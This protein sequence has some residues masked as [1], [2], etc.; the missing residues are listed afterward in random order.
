MYVA[1]CL[2]GVPRNTY[3]PTWIGK[4]CEKYNTKVF[5]N[6]WLP[7][8]DFLQ[9]SNTPGPRDAYILDENIYRYPNSES[10]FTTNNWSEMK[11]TFEDLYSQVEHGQRVRSDLG[12]ISMFY[13]LYRAQLMAEEYEKNNK[14]EFGIVIRSR[15]DTFVKQG[16]WDYDLSKF[17]VNNTLYYPDYNVNTCN[18]H[19]GLSSSQIMRVYGRV[20]ENLVELTRKAGYWPERML[21]AQLGSNIE[22]KLVD[23]IGLP[24]FVGGPME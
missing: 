3:F 13:S 8:Q 5:V 17:D 19:W 23:F 16:K 21:A 4:I 1:I 7:H 20:Y 6:Y 12:V 10:F 24:R 18:D 11:P 15:M 22:C 2:S 14:I 9:H